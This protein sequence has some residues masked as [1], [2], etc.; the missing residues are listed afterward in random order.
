MKQL[1][2]AGYEYDWLAVD[3]DG[4]VALFSTAGSGFAPESFLRDIDAH[5]VAI[6]AILSAPPTTSVRFSP[7]VPPD[8]DNTWRRV[9]ERGV[10]AFDTD[11]TGGP[12]RL[13]AAP[14]E[15]AKLGQLP[16][17]VS[18]AVEG[19]TITSRS[20]AHVTTITDADLLAKAPARGDAS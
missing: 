8:R 9:A 1:D 17:A 19:I 18:R 2:I 13:V 3:G 7:D 15:P 16:L 10:F 20:F 4:H 11:P 5:D 12:Y 6:E 14:G